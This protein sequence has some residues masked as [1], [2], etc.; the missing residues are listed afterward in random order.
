MESKHNLE[1]Y[2]H[3]YKRT[4]QIL[5]QYPESLNMVKLYADYYSEYWHRRN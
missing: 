5:V 1:V 4:E 3:Y 2:Y